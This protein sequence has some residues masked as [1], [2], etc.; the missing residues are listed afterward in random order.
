MKLP[1]PPTMNLPTVPEN[2]VAVVKT[3]SAMT[4]P[5]KAP[6]SFLFLP[7]E[8]RQAI[9]LHTLK[10]ELPVPPPQIREY[11]SLPH[12]SYNQRAEEEEALI[13]FLLHS[14]PFAAYTDLPRCL[15]RH[16]LLRLYRH[17]P[18]EETS[19]YYHGSSHQE[20]HNH[21]TRST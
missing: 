17:C 21:C 7:R 13:F 20:S 5:A 2:V 19:R 3:S 1:P 18:I 16:P 4:Q 14:T 6:I 15:H 9:L 8:L 12:L 11:R 10:V